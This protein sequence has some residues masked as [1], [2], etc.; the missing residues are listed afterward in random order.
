M[1]S[2]RSKVHTIFPP[3]DREKI[4]E[5]LPYWKGKSM[6]DLSKTALPAHIEECIQDDIITVGLRNGVSG[7]TPVTM[8]SF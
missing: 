2:G 4:L 3:E 1:N 5:L 7:E 8:K 6:E